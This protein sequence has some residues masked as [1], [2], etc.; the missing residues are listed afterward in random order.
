MSKIYYEYEKF[1]NDLR[2]IETWIAESNYKP[3]VIVGLIRGGLV[4]STYLSHQINVPVD[5]LK[6]S[7][8]DHV[9]FDMK[10][11][12]SYVNHITDKYQ[13]I[14]VIDDIVDSGKTLNL[15]ESCIHKSLKKQFR[16][17][18]MW[19][20]IK[21]NFVVDYSP[22]NYTSDNVSWISFPWEKA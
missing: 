3:D 14:L 15:L 10:D 16:Y 20:N 11:I 21:S 12:Y 22:N 9:N 19:W 8:R 1:L 6:L 2:I 17:I 4:P 7:T 18:S 5:T 13:N